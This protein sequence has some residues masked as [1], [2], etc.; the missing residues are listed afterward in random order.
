MVKYVTCWKCAWSSYHQLWNMTLQIYWAWVCL[1]SKRKVWSCLVWFG[2]GLGLVWSGLVQTIHFGFWKIRK[3]AATSEWVD[4]GILAVLGVVLVKNEH[5]F[6]DTAE[7]SQPVSECVLPGW[8]SLV[9]TKA[10]ASIG[11]WRSPVDPSL[12]WLEDML[13]NILTVNNSTI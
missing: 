6:E 13:K 2:S 11:R 9:G 7:K 10:W 12:P 1:L 3:H 5:I 8:W 4:V